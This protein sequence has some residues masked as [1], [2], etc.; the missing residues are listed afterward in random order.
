MQGLKSRYPKIQMTCVLITDEKFE[1]LYAL[2]YGEVLPRPVNQFLSGQ[3][4]SNEV[5]VVID[6]LKNQH[7]QIKSLYQAYKPQIELVRGDEKNP[8]EEIWFVEFI[9]EN[10]TAICNTYGCSSVQFRCI[11]KGWKP[12]LFTAPVS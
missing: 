12:E 1:Q 7:E 6:H 10:F 3:Q 4:D 11:V 8:Q 2:L 5:V 9:E